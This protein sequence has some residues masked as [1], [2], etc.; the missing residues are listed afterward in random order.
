MEIPKRR[1]C[2]KPGIF[3]HVWHLFLCSH[4]HKNEAA[5]VAKA[6]R[7][8]RTFVGKWHDGMRGDMVAEAKETVRVLSCRISVNAR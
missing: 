2:S 6:T 5:V 8:S 4:S 7:A 3:F 1:I